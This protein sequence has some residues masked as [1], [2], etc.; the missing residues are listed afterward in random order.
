MSDQPPPQSQSMELAKLYEDGKHRRYSLLFAINGGAFAVAKLVTQDCTNHAC[1]LGA[2]KLW[3][4]ALGMML[5][6]ATMVWD[7]YKFGDK[8]SEKVD[9]AFTWIGKTGALLAGCIDHCG[10][11]SGGIRNAVVPYTAASERRN[12]SQGNLLSAG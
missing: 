5:M 3:E 4:L 10:V 1:V 2:L 12:S 11:V 9:R 7:I 6:T 8:M